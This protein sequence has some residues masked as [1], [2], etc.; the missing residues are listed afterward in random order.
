VSAYT[1][2]VLAD[3]PFFYL[4]LGESSGTVAADASGN[5]RTGTYAGSPT[6]GATGALAAID[7]NTA[8]QTDG[9]ND[10]CTITGSTAF[11]PETNAGGALSIEFWLK[12][13]ATGGAA[14]VT[15]G[16]VC[17]NVDASNK[18][19]CVDLDATGH[20]L[21]RSGASMTTI[22]T[23]TIVV[24]DGVWRHFVVTITSSAS[25]TLYINGVSNATGTYAG[26]G[27]GTPA[28]T[29]GENPRAT[30]PFTAATFDEVSLYT[31]TLS[32][33]RVLAHYMAGAAGALK[34]QG[35]TVATTT[36]TT[37]T[38]N[39]WGS[40][41]VAGNWLIMVV[42]INRSSAVASANAVSGWTGPI[43]LSGG[44]EAINSTRHIYFGIYYRQATGVNTAGNDAAPAVT[45]SN[46]SGCVGWCDE[47]PLLGGHDADGTV[48]DTNATSG[49]ITPS[50]VASA[51]SDLCYTV[52]AGN[53]GVIPTTCS[54]AGGA[55]GDRAVAFFNTDLYYASA[56]Q[57]AA[58]SGTISPTNTVAGIASTG[59]PIIGGV[60]VAF[61]AATPKSL[62]L[63]ER[64]IRRNSLLRR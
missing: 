30:T 1:N 13:T 34:V 54:F 44:N 52:A 22:V 4:R 62:V 46:N 60:S 33:A 61:L 15:G 57:A 53:S 23:S 21:F 7:T 38:N 26:G 5:S 42:L 39:A 6:L 40:A 14:N 16:L 48:Q 56:Y 45:V 27:S 36:T 35:T 18:R 3:S 12:T 59:L 51:A 32:A 47:F 11:F 20:L 31:T 9:T 43:S 2:A 19:W 58:A 10:V 28:I 24:N 50:V 49:T 55:I 63:D 64:R 41:P 29:V 8:L 37:L 25:T 17:C